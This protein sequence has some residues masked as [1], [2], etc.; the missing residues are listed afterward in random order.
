MRSIGE[1]LTDKEVDEMVREAD[2]DGDGQIDYHEFV[3]VVPPAD[4]FDAC[5]LL[6]STD[7]DV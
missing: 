2:V 7:D 3:K 1:R 4:P 6:F 5:V